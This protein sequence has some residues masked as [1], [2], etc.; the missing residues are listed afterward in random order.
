MQCTVFLRKDDGWMACNC[1]FFLIVFQS[2]Q[3]DPRVIIKAVY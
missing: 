3:D 2:N 1:T